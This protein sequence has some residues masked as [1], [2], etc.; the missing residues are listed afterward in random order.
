[1][2][3]IYNIFKTI[4]FNSNKNSKKT[5]FSKSTN[6]KSYIKISRLPIFQNITLVNPKTCLIK[7]KLLKKNVSKQENVI[8]KMKFF[9]PIQGKNKKSKINN[10]RNYIICSPNNKSN[11][12]RQKLIMTNN[13]N[14]NSINLSNLS[15]ASME[16]KIHRKIKNENRILIN[17]KKENNKL[18]N[19]IDKQKVEIERLKN[20]NKKY[21][22]KLHI[23]EKEKKD[24]NNQIDEYNSNQEQLILLIKIIQNFGIDI[25]KIIDDYNNS[26]IDYS[27][28]ID[29]NSIKNNESI[30]ELD[31][32]A[33]SNSFIPINIEKKPQSKISKINIPKL[34]FEKINKKNEKGFYKNYFS[35]SK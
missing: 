5:I 34:N 25:D 19:L 14:S 16:Q 2:S 3:A 20:K 6:N 21:N 10:Q 26:I 13:S 1:M 35:I 33:E 31:I 8:E 24:L 12:L 22:Q 32:K 27:F 15:K 11:Y 17:C 30:S 4:Y 7:N 28:K 18:T 23:L 9:N 29:N